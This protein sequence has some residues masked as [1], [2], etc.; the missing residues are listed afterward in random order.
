MG[1]THIAAIPMEFKSEREGDIYVLADNELG[2]LGGYD[3]QKM[4]EL[5]EQYEL[6]DPSNFEGTGLTMDRAED[7]LAGA[8]MV[9]NAASVE[10]MGERGYSEDAMAAAERASQIAAG[11]AMRE[12]VLMLTPTQREQYDQDVKLLAAHYGLTSVIEIVIRAIHEAALMAEV[13]DRTDEATQESSEDDR[14][15]DTVVPDQ[16]IPY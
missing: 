10:T 16:D 14:Q 4:Y 15:P 5:M 11:K 7:I 12:T 3:E 6:F 8:G 1:W 13:M 9:P 2:R